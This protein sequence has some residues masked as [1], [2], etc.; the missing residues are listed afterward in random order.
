MLSFAILD[1]HIQIQKPF[2][3]EAWKHASQNAHFL[4]QGTQKALNMGS[5]NTLKINKNQ[6]W[7]SKCPF[8][9]SPVSQS[10]PGLPQDAEVKPPSLPN[11]RFGY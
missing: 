8:L 1:I 5:P 2:E 7:T 10:R 9:C 11:N 3:K 6:A 4:V